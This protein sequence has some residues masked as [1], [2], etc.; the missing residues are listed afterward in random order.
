[1]EA[2]LDCQSQ[3]EWRWKAG[4]DD[5]SLPP[6]LHT[7]LIMCEARADA[8][9]ILIDLSDSAMQ[10]DVLVRVIS[11]FSI[12][13]LQYEAVSGYDTSFIGE[14]VLSACEFF[15]HGAG[16]HLIFQHCCVIAS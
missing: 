9:N 7:Q 15:V 3:S 8:S 6:L 2:E 5:G 4:S 14:I 10:S 13:D 16:K 11:F 1:M 12:F